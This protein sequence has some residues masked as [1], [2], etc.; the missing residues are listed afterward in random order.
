M[1]DNWA[2]IL[3]TQDEALRAQLSELMSRIPLVQLLFKWRQQ[4]LLFANAD[5]LDRVMLALREKQDTIAT[6]TSCF[7]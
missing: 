6:T 4:I 2:K 1:R 5:L 3:E 7:N